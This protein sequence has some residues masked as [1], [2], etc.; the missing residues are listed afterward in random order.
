[1][2]FIFDCCIWMKPQRDRARYIHIGEPT[3]NV[4]IKTAALQTRK[5]IIRKHS[6]HF[7]IIF[8]FVSFVRFSV[9][10]K[11]EHAWSILMTHSWATAPAHTKN[12][13]KNYVCVYKILKPRR[14]EN[15]GFQL[16]K[17]GAMWKCQMCCAKRLL[18]LLLLHKLMTLKTIINNKNSQSN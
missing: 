5:I 10:K 8:F 15:M 17:L 9:F 14:K 6:T 3:K 12:K 4:K 1:M 13:N 2:C 18:L 11:E 7:W 16:T